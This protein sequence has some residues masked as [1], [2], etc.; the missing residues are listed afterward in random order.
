MAQITATYAK[1]NLDRVWEMAQQEPVEVTSNGAPVAFILSPDEYSRLCQ[2]QTRIGRPRR[3]G[4]LSK[5]F[6]DFDT[7]A[8]LNVDVTEAFQDNL[9]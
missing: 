1:N 9:Q 8:L 6:A 3:I 2:R 5:E 4:L 7:D